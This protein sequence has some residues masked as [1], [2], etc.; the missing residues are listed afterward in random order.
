MEKKYGRQSKDEYY[1]DIALARSKRSTCLRR[2]IGAEIVKDDTSISSG[3]NGSARGAPN[4]LEYGC[5]KEKHNL[6]HGSDYD[7]CRAGPL[8]AENNSIINAGRGRGGTLGATMYLAGE[9][10]D[11]SGTFSVY[12]CKNC[13]KVILNAGIK[14]VVIKTKKG[15]KKLRPKDWVKQAHR[16]KNKDVLSE[17]K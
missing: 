17:Y 11:G 5:L 2:H 12:P 16:T 13:M 4:C 7:F 9:Y 14:E 15:I 3:Y 8:H 1:L 10:A 6:P